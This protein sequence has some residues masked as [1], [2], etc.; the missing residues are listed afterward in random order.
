MQ[1]QPGNQPRAQDP[2]TRHH[3]REKTNPT[4]LETRLMLIFNCARQRQKHH[5]ND[6]ASH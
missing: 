1:L 6:V 5:P 2:V 3:S 4:S